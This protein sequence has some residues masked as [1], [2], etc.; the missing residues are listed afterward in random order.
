MNLKDSL[1]HKIRQI[2]PRPRNFDSPFLLLYFYYIIHLA[3]FKQLVDTYANVATV[4]A[5]RHASFMLC[6][7][8]AKVA[9]SAKRS[10]YI[11]RR[12]TTG[13]RTLEF[14][15]SFRICFNTAP[16]L[17]PLLIVLSSAPRQESA[18][19]L[20]F[21]I[22][23]LT[24][25]RSHVSRNHF[26]ENNSSLAEYSGNS[27]PIQLWVNFSEFTRD[28]LLSSSVNGKKYYCAA[29]FRAATPRSRVGEFFKL[30]S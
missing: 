25:T 15:I 27:S 11:Y 5:T 19:F 28:V 13:C 23:R 9:E 12:N 22:I 8:A 20:N 2:N 17:L 24:R 18:I 16:D 4:C 29:P 6:H 26:R 1:D 7:S 21:R 30:P 3:F 10:F 14:H